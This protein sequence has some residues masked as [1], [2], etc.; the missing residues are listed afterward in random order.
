MIEEQHGPHGT[1]YTLGGGDIVVWYD[2]CLCIKTNPPHA[3]R[4]TEE[5]AQELAEL[6]CRLIDRPIELSPVDETLAGSASGAL[7]TY[8]TSGG[9]IVIR[10]GDGISIKTADGDPLDISD[11]EAA[12]L[13]ETLFLA[14][15][16]PR[17]AKVHDV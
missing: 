17:P 3:V 14:M 7:R 15:T 11:D 13:A 8:E 1:R 10:A 6:L 12:D 5:E 2:S 16:P 4:L 9:D